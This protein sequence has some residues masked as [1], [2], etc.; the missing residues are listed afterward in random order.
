MRRY[1]TTFEVGFFVLRPFEKALN[2]LLTNGHIA[3]YRIDGRW[4]TRYVQIFDADEYALSVLRD[5]EC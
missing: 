1:D 5:M 3:G 2:R 4:L